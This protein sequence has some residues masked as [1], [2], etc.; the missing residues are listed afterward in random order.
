M[1]ASMCQTL[2]LHSYNASTHDAFAI[3]ATQRRLFWTVYRF[4]KG[5]ALRLGRSSN[6]RDSDITLPLDPNEPR[7]IKLG[8][9]QGKAYDELYSP[10]GLLKQNNE[11]GD[12]AAELAGQLRTLI[13]ETRAELYVRVHSLS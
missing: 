10:A 6:I 13:D 1:A 9:I 4:E 5:L 7:Q 3:Q 2:K 8:R 12:S 11:R